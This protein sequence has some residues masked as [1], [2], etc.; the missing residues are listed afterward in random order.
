MAD[1]RRRCEVGAELERALQRLT[2]NNDTW[3]A[4]FG[5]HACGT[6]W[7]REYPFAEYHGGGPSCLYQADV[8]EPDA[9]LKQATGITPDLRR[10]E[11]DASFLSLL[12]PEIGPELC[13]AEPCPSLRIAGSVHCRNHHFS[14]LQGHAAAVAKV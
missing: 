9:Y 10:V 8:P 1:V 14:A 2:V 5:C 12:G 13:R 3:M 7:V 6:R 4:V 11:E